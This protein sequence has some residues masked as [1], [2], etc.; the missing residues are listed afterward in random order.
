MPLFRVVAN[1]FESMAEDPPHSPRPA[2]LDCDLVQIPRPQLLFQFAV[3]GQNLDRHALKPIQR[4][5]AAVEKLF[6]VVF[7]RITPVGMIYLWPETRG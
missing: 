3:G 5:P 2:Y 4:E 6:E 1:D 7:R